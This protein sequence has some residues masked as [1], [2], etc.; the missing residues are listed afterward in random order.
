MV[1]LNRGKS[2]CTDQMWNRQKYM[3]LIYNLLPDL[4]DNIYNTQHTKSHKNGVPSYVGTTMK[5]KDKTDTTQHSNQCISIKKSSA[6]IR[7]AHCRVI[8]VYFSSIVLMLWT[9]LLFIVLAMEDLLLHKLEPFTGCPFFSCAIHWI[10]GGTP[11][12]A[13][14]FTI[15]MLRIMYVLWLLLEWKKNIILAC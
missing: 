13:E 2:T 3:P 5:H 14:S 12:W 8:L 4:I 9:V 10:V 6:E 1:Y 11:S 15:A 7:N